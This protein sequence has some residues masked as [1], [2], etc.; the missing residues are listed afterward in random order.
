VLRSQLP[1]D[2]FFLSDGK[3]FCTGQFWK[4]HIY[5]ARLCRVEALEF[6]I[7]D[8]PEDGL[9]SSNKALKAYLKAQKKFK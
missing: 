6:P 7:R 8:E 4:D 5:A 2:P 9:P 3:I 1:D